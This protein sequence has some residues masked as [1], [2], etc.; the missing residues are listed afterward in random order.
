MRKVWTVMVAGS[1]FLLGACGGSSKTSTSSGTSATTAAGE[2]SATCSPK[3]NSITVVAKNI[4]FDTN[5]IAVTAGQ[6]FTVTLDNEDPQTPH[7]LAFLASHTSAQVFATT[8]TFTGVDKKT[9]TFTP[10]KFPG[11]GTYHFHCEVHPDQ[12]NGTFIIK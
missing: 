1:L 9:V 3:G 8:G 11:P 10:D 2:S 12:M 6:P 4:K 5:C 7:S